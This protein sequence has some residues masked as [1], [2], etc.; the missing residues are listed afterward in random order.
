MHAMLYIEYITMTALVSLIF[1]TAYH[2]YWLH[3]SL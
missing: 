2:P 3:F 1:I